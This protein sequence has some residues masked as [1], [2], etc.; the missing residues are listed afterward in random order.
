ME[1]VSSPDYWKDRLNKALESNCIH[2]SVFL[3]SEVKWEAIQEKHRQ[4]LKHY[5]S[6]NSKVLDVGCGY[7]RLVDLLRSH[8]PENYHGIDVSPDLITIAKITHPNYLFSVCS[9]L[10]LHTFLYSLQLG[11]FDWAVLISMRPM[12][13]RNLGDEVWSQMEREIRLVAKQL[14]FLEYDETDE[15]SVE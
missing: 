14:L 4:I 3:C 13:K 10:N 9:I 2:H 1:P 6:P 12:I 11:Y 5:V 7:G 15:G 8:P